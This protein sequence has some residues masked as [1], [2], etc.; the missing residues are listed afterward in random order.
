MFKLWFMRVIFDIRINITG[1]SCNF[2]NPSRCDFPFVCGW[3][4]ATL[5]AIRMRG[6]FHFPSRFRI[7]ATARIINFPITFRISTHSWLY[8][9]INFRYRV[10]LLCVLW[11]V[12]R[13][14]FSLYPLFRATVRMHSECRCCRF[15]FPI[16]CRD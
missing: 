12:E 8:A 14:P 1:A 4:S 15:A 6:A 3:L 9:Y 10:R 5:V 13:R 11:R 16:F 7:R 2:L